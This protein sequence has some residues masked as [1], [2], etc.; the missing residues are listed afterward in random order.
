M[1]SNVTAGQPAK[2]SMEAVDLAGNAVSGVSAAWELFDE[3]GASLAAGTVDPYDGSSG[4][5]EFEIAAADT[6]LA[7]G[8]S[9]EGR[10]IVVTVTES[11]GDLIEIRDYFVIV[12][13]HQLQLMKNTF[14]TYPQA[15]SLRQT[16]G[17]KM[18]GWDA[19]MDHQRRI[20]A[21]VHAYANLSR[22]AY[23]IANNINS[24][25][26]NYA[27]WGEGYDG[28]FDLSYR[29]RLKTLSTDQFNT[30]PS[31]FTSAMK[32]AQMVEANVLLGGD[33]VGEKRRDGIISE[34]I[35]E[36]STFFNSKPYLSLPFSRQAFEIVRPYI[37]IQ[38]RIAR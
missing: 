20:Q 4:T 18:D 9:S 15:L 2:I 5:I 10:E 33:I 3:A 21:L 12:A 29:V 38:T 8:V 14:V 30:L 22:V 28:P 7:D 6:G 32:R 37:S 11:D 24:N 17:G 23:F 34:T 35:G 1:I 31:N 19:E 36:S 16:F 25:P 26:K 13:A 27:A